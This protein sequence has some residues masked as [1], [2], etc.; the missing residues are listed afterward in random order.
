[1][2]VDLEARP[3]RL[4]DVERL[5]V[6]A[7]VRHERSGVVRVVRRQRHDAV[8]LDRD[9]LHLVQVHDRDQVG[10]RAGVAVVIGAAPDPGQRA[11]ETAALFTLDTEVPG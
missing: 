1:V 9:H 3:L 5:D 10:H 2:P 11:H 8:V 4:V 6:G 7:L